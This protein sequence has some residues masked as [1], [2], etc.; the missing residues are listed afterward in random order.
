MKQ[1]L[2]RIKLNCTCFVHKH[3]SHSTPNHI[4]SPFSAHREKISIERFGCG[5]MAG[6]ECVAA[7]PTFSPIE[8]WTSGDLCAGLFSRKKTNKIHSYCFLCTQHYK[9]VYC[10]V[11]KL[12]RNVRFVLLLGLSGDALKLTESLSTSF[13]ISFCVLG[14]SLTLRN[15][16][17]LHIPR[18][19][20][21][22]VQKFLSTNQ[23]I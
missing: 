19:H 8:Y 9:S 15:C 11:G 6:R 23:Y 10:F 18:A 1:E 22:R 7:M 4:H 12:K 5:R 13:S 16:A 14:S 21:I 2:E 20:N 3:T 17:L